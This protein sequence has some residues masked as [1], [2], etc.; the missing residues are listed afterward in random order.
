MNSSTIVA[1]VGLTYKTT[2]PADGMPRITSP[3]AAYELLKTL[4]DKD[5]IQLQEHFVIVL[6]DSQKR[7]L[8]YTTISKGG[9]TSTIVEP[10]FIFQ[11]ALLANADGILLCHNH[12]G[13]ELRASTADINLTSRLSDAGKLLGIQI[14]DHIIL[15]SEGYLSMKTR[16]LF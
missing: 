12:P 4:F 11:T 8:G 10:K 13:S 15:T 14:I 9:S 7:C 2:V 16:G 6:L 5:T 1:E 3:D